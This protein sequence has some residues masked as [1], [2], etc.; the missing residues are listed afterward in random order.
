MDSCYK[1]LPKQIFQTFNTSCW[2]AVLESWIGILPGRKWHPTEAE[3]IDMYPDKTYPDGSV[4]PAELEGEIA[5]ISGMKSE[6]T[7]KSDLTATYLA[8]KLSSQGHL[9]LGFSRGSLGG[10]V[11]V[12]YGVGRPTG[13]EQLV[14]VMDP[15]GGEGYKNRSFSVFKPIPSYG[16]VFVGWPDPG[17]DMKYF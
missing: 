6:W 16:K 1:A 5:K 13:K 11:V 17:I 15:S 9:V 12:C 2:A 14:A 7:S 4:I 10:H 3:L 8:D